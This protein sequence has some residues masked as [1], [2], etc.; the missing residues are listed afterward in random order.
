[1]EQYLYV[2]NT[3]LASHT[4]AIWSKQETAE[5]GLKA[6]KAEAIQYMKEQGVKL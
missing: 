3:I 1:M 2:A 6:A 5:A 4:G